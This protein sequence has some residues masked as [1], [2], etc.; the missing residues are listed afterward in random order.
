M[1][2][3]AGRAHWTCQGVAVGML[4][5]WGDLLRPMLPKESFLSVSPAGDSVGGANGRKMDLSFLQSP[6]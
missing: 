4:L 1:V 3:S 6:L 2:C 5:R